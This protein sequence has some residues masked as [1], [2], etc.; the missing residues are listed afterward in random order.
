MQSIDK[1]SWALRFATHLRQLQPAIEGAEA[2]RIALATFDDA[3]DLTPEEAAEIYAL[4]E[5]PG[6]VGAPGN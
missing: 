3:S 6:D 4:E 2:M 5:P 1:A